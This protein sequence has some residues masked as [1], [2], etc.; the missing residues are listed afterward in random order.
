MVEAI[1]FTFEPLPIRKRTLVAVDANQY[2]VMGGPSEVKQIQ[3]STAYEA[4]RLSGFKHAIKIERASNFARAI[5]KKEQFS[6]LLAQS[7]DLMSAHS[8]GAA[9]PKGIIVSA[10]DME[11]LMHRL[12]VLATRDA[13][14]PASV[15]LEPAKVVVDKGNYASP[16][17][18][19]VHGEGFDEI[20]P[21]TPAPKPLISTTKPAQVREQ[22]QSEP[23]PSSGPAIP[24]KE[25]SKEEIEKLL[26]GK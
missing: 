19:D 4:Y 11:V 5:L 23:Q 17:G 3:A 9:R 16:S 14:T 26:G 22:A 24:E 6:D 25:L 18:M 20:I 15:P 1:E 8:V 12:Q 13:I 21:A 7:P 2:N 10:D